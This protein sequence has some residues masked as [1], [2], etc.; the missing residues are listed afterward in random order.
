MQKKVSLTATV[1]SHNI[2]AKTPV[3]ESTDN[4]AASSQEPV[5]PSPSVDIS[6]GT[7]SATETNSPVSE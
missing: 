5:N 6:E 2:A 7:N 4:V 3:L 1:P